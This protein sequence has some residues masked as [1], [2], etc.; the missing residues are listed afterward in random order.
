[1]PLHGIASLVPWHGIAWH[2]MASHRLFHGIASHG[3]GMEW[4]SVMCNGE[5]AWIFALHFTAGYEGRVQTRT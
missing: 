5:D 3:I 1:M 2:R 4:H